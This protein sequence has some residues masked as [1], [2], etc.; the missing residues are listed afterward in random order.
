MT[1]N[2]HESHDYRVTVQY[3]QLQEQ[4]VQTFTALPTVLWSAREFE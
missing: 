1:H 2:R 4:V 3:Q